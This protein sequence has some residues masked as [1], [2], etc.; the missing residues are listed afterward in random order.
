MGVVMKT[1]DES[2]LAAAV[3]AA[4]PGIA[5]APWIALRLLQ[6]D[7]SVRRALENFRLPYLTVTPTF[8]ICPR[9]GYLAGEH[10]YCPKCDAEIL[11]RKRA[12]LAAGEL[13]LDLYGMREPL[14]KAGL[15]YID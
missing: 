9:H 7:E 10:A 14:A 5:N 13:G 3:E 12:R 8:S 1:R 2:R 15:K 6:G 11:A 4:V